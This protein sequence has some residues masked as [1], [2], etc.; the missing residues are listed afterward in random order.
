MQW[1]RKQNVVTNVVFTSLKA[2]VWTGCYFD[3]GCSRHMTGNKANLT[4]IKEVKT[5]F[6]T[7]GGGEKGKIIGK[8]SLNVEGLPNL[9]EVLLVERL[10]ANLISIS[11]LCDNGM[12]VAFDR[13]TCSVSNQNN[14]LI[15][16]GSRSTDN[17]YLWTPSQKALTS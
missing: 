17:C 14:D 2:T 8:G 3:S 1:V 4:S 11:Q 15:M 10:T 16:Q 13:S 9:E 7:F 6:V 12:K 5:D